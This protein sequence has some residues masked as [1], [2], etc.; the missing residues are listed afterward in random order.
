[1][2]YDELT[3]NKRQKKDANFSALLNG[4]RCSGPTEE[5]LSALRDHVI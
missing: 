5:E 4:V 1:M 3:I 2:A